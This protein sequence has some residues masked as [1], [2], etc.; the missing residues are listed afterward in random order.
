MHSP[1]SREHLSLECLGSSFVWETGRRS[2]VLAQILHTHTH[3]H[4]Y[5]YVCVSVCV[6]DLCRVQATDSKRQQSLTSPSGMSK[7][8]CGLK[9]CIK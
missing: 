2:C 9:E 8:T 4:I 3:T 5:I 1:F 6:C 7:N